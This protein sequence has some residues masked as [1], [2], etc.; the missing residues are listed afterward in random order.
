M[1]A[2]YVVPGVHVEVDAFRARGDH[3]REVQYLGRTIRVTDV[4]VEIEGN[5]KHV[6]ELLETLGMTECKGVGTPLTAEDLKSP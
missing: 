2:G 6:R 1:G 5:P 4:G 3:A